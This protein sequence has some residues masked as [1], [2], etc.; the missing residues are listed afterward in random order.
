MV[1][2]EKLAIAATAV[3][4]VI[5]LVIGM[6]ALDRAGDAQRSARAVAG[7]TP[8]V[9]TLVAQ[10]SVA[11]EPSVAS[12]PPAAGARTPDRYPVAYENQHLR[13][14]NA[15][16]GSGQAVD[17]DEPRVAPPDGAELTFFACTDTRFAFEGP[18]TFAEVTDP[19]ANATAC[20]DA[21]R[22]NP[23]VE[24]LRVARGQTVCVLTSGNAPKIVRLQ[25]DAVTDRVALSLTA[26][27]L[28]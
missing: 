13:L 21:L 20:L 9:P 8:P 25:T 3:V 22:T 5:A 1:P 12:L 16:V 26:W 27:T 2:T 23:G 15:C 10:Q 19:Q 4:A 24:S 28:V 18:T 7:R 6:V 17:L 11:P 14:Q